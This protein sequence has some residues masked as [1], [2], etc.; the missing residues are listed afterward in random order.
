MYAYANVKAR[1]A[2]EGRCKPLSDDGG[3]LR[4]RVDHGEGGG[5]GLGRGGAELRGVERV[6]PAEVRGPLRLP[7]DG[8]AVVLL[9]RSLL[10]LVRAEGLDL[11]HLEAPRGSPCPHEPCRRSAD[12]CRLAPSL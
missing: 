9:P 8:V 10:P 12:R 7:G 2:G 1:E 4:V 3:A 6:L 11:I 5:P